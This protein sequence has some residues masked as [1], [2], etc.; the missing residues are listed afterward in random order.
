MQYSRRQFIKQAGIATAGSVVIPHLTW[1]ESTP[2]TSN[3]NTL[4][5]GLIGCGGRGTAAA[6]KR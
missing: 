6:Q 3:S 5:V 4:K 2:W 1:A